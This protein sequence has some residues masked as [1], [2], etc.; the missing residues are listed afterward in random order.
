MEASITKLTFYHI[1]CFLLSKDA[2]TPN[3]AEFGSVS[4][5]QAINLALNQSRIEILRVLKKLQNRQKLMKFW[6]VLNLWHPESSNFFEFSKS[7]NFYYSN[8]W[9]QICVIRTNLKSAVWIVKVDRFWKFKKKLNYQDVKD[10]ER[11]KTSLVS[12]CFEAFCESAKFQFSTD[13]KLNLLRLLWSL[14]Q[15]Q[16]N[17]VWM[18]LWTVENI[19]YRRK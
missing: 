18:H 10:S 13:L 4:L 3:V 5:V 2:F 11:F 17:L 14:D 19:W 6:I 1:R 7:V 15:I 12:A 8:S 9:L 16:P